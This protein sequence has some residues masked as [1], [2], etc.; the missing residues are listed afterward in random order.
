[1]TTITISAG[2]SIQAAIDANPAGTTFLFADGV[3]HQQQINPKNGD[4]FIGAADGGTI[5]S[6]DNVT[7]ELANNGSGNLGTGVLFE[8]ITVQNY[9][10]GFQQGAISGVVNW[11]FQ[12]DTFQFMGNS[13]NGLDPGADCQIIG[14]HY[15]NN[16]A[17]GISATQA[18]NLVI[19]GAEIAYNNTAHLNPDNDTGGLK[20]TASDNVQI[21]NSNVHDNW[22][23]GL[24]ADVRDTNWTI[25]G[26]TIANNAYNGIQWETSDGV[27]ISNNIITGNGAGPGMPME[28]AAVY[29]SSSG[30]ADVY[31]NTITVPSGADGIVMQ[32][33]DRADQVT[34]QGNVVHDNTV[35]FLGAN[36]ENGWRNYGGS[37]GAGNSFDSN[38]YY[39]A[40][41]SDAHWIWGGSNAVMQWSSYLA[42]SGQDASGS[43]QAGIASTP[44]LSDPATTSPVAGMPASDVSVGTAPPPSA[45]GTVVLGTSGDI[46]TAAGNTYAIDAA[47][48]I[49]KNGAV[50]PITDGVTE[51]A[52]VHGTLYQ[53]AT[54]AH[55]WWSY[56]E[57]ADQW[58]VTSDPLPSGAS[59]TVDPTQDLLDLVSLSNSGGS[60]AVAPLNGIK[61]T[62]TQTA[63]PALPVDHTA[64]DPTDPTAITLDSILPHSHHA[65]HV[66]A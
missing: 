43:E 58:T 60:N 27:T 65:A 8:H 40:S 39:V 66:V 51:L 50:L 35:T 63:A 29:I 5:L 49:T 32:S 11:T 4:Q 13:G 24:W 55:M 45:D 44:A 23:T 64:H 59:T 26:N 61:I 33:I 30:H 37:V 1:M 52:Y 38:H 7:G 57:A 19:N 46:V 21:L 62:A 25:S 3:W 47:G 14:G 28:G 2:A 53:E 34:T 20:I 54:S 9:V 48:Q 56:N 41:L 36:G 42:A 22:G 16:A 17:N 10:P 15:V 6:G 31:G 18:N 12:N